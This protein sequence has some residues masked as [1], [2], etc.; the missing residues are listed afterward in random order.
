VQRADDSHPVRRSVQRVVMTH[1]AGEI[2]VGVFVDRALQHFTP[3]RTR[4]DSG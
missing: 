2:K 1:F 3:T 4:T